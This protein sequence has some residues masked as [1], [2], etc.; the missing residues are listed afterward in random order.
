VI[1]MKERIKKLRKELKLT[2]Q[3]FADKL[4]IKRNTIANYELGRNA[5]V[6]SVLALICRTFR[7]NEEWLRAG[8]G[9]MFLPPEESNILDDPSLDDMDKRILRAYAELPAEIRKVIKQKMREIVAEQEN[10][11]ALDIEEVTAENL[12]AEEK[13][14]IKKMRIE[15]NTFNVNG[16]TINF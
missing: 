5:P 15:K 7:V 9:E 2:Q 14:A 3:G 1:F 16:G 4:G 12:T 11:P 13:A 6:D 10:F 8:V